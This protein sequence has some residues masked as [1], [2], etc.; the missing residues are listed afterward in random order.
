MGAPAWANAVLIEF[1]LDSFAGPD[2]LWIDDI[3]VTT[4]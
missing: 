1:S 4:I 2:S 3:S